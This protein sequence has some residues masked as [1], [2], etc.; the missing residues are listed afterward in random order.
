M[1]SFKSYYLYKIVNSVNDKVYIGMSGDVERRKYQHFNHR[2]K[3]TISIIKLAIDK[4]GPENFEFIILCEGSRE[5]I[6]DLEK[7][8]IVAYDSINNGY[9]IR[10]GGEGGS[11][12]KI[13]NRSDDTPLFVM[14]FWFPNARTCLKHISISKGM[15]YRMLREGRAGEFISKNRV[16]N[17]ANAPV[18]VAGFWF[19]NFETASYILSKTIPTLRKRIYDGFIEQQGNSETCGLDH[20]TT[21]K[22]GK[23]CPNSKA[24]YVDDVLYDSIKLAGKF[25]NYSACTISRGL[26]N[27]DP[28]FSYKINENIEV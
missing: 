14:G 8:A 16:K 1:N 22:T 11:G 26:K 12:H 24:V 28:R 2:S 21:G 9:N 6:I 25:S 19:N 3:K 20:P 7:K 13:S 17:P 10:A 27:K 23:L 5:Y 15:L 4:Y 18:Y